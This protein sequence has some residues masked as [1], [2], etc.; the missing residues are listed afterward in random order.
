MDK[1]RKATVFFD[2]YLSY[3]DMINVLE[4]HAQ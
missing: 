2:I 1:D 4:R 3:Q